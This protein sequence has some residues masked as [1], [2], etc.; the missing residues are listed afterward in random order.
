MRRGSESDVYPIA[1][2]NLRR[3]VTSLPENTSTRP[4]SLLPGMQVTKV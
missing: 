2:A 4:E 1:Q 3:G